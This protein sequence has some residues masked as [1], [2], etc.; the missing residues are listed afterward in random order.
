LAELLA[1]QGEL[2][3]PEELPIPSGLPSKAVTLELAAGMPVPGDTIRRT[4][5]LMLE[6]MKPAR[7]FV[8]P[9]VRK[10]STTFAGG[11]PVPE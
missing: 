5:Q 2:P 6:P 10:P 3:A 7:P 1:P 8:L 9:S 4:A 11:L